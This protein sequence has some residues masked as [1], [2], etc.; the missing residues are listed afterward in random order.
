M[1]WK[2]NFGGSYATCHSHYYETLLQFNF[3]STTQRDQIV[4][5]VGNFVNL[6][7][8]NN[9]QNCW[10]VVTALNQRSPFNDRPMDPQ[11]GSRT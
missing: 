5:N 10:S 6:Q 7:I 1:H 11:S 4:N 3:L 8:L 2:G 9:S